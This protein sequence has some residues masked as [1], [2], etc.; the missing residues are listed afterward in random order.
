M[1][2]IALV[3]ALV[4]P[5]W[6]DRL[7]YIKLTRT[8]RAVAADLREARTDALALQK[9]TTV[10]IDLAA[11]RVNG[12]AEDSLVQIPESIAVR[13]I[14]TDSERLNDHSGAIRFYPDGS[15]TGGRVQFS[16]GLR[17]LSVDVNWLTGRVRILEGDNA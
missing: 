5:N 12:A 4:V 9:E 13:L 14:G 1:L 7:Q 10:V 3:S 11:R 16:I 6:R 2:L 8:V 15:S 17:N